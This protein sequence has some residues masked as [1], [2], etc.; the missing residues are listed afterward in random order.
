MRSDFA[1]A[2]KEQ[3]ASPRPRIQLMQGGNQLSA[4][5]CHDN[6]RCIG[7]RPAPS[8][9]ETAKRGNEEDCNKPQFLSL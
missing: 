2:G 5:N 6:G 1:A 3:R 9:L 4:G 8:E 7:S